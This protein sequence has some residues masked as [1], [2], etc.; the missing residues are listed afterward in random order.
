M[1]RPALIA[2]VMAA[3]MAL[4]AS[5]MAKTHWLDSYDPGS[6]AASGPIKTERLVKRIPYKVAVRGTFSL[7]SR[8]E[9]KSSACGNPE[10]KPIYPS[11]RRPNGAVVADAEFLFADVSRNCAKRPSVQTAST[12]QLKTS[13]KY[14]D[15]TPIGGVGTAPKPNH[16]Y[17]YAV[18]G[19]GK[20]A[21]FRLIDDF[22]KDNYGRLR[23][24]ITRARATDCAANGFANWN[25]VDEATCVA[26]TAR[27][28]KR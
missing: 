5:A 18:T 8:E 11:K 21:R 24:T 1:R 23:I 3:F 9:I 19:A 10:P 6:D 13:A 14:R 16:L 15:A 28:I 17:T 27:E 2:V 25:Y 4:P 20:L 26:A 22:T 12:F 7:F